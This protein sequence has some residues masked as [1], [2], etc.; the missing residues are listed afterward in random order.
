MTFKIQRKVDGLIGVLLLW[1][2]F[3]VAILGVALSFPDW[4]PSE[5]LFPSGLVMSTA[6]MTSL[7][8]LAVTS[9]QFDAIRQ[10]RQV[11]LIWS[12]IARQRVNFSSLGSDKRRLLVGSA[13]E[14]LA[15]TEQAYDAV[16]EDDSTKVPTSFTGELVEL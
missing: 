10:H 1:F 13:L 15:L 5:Y 3:S 12:E 7:V 14:T 2:F 6:S 4:E 8:I 9:H 11:E 16:L